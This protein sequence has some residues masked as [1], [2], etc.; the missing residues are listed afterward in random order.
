MSQ[1]STVSI[2]QGSL[3]YLMK[4][5][6]LCLQIYGTQKNPFRENILS[7]LASAYQSSSRAKKATGSSWLISELSLWLESKEN[8]L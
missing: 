6:L 3:N 7:V 8:T 1:I 5:T 4:K 2:V